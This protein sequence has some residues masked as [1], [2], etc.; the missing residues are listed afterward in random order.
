MTNLNSYKT[1]LCVAEEKNLTKASNKLFVSQPAISN[2]IKELEKQLSC[3]LFIRKNKGVE[4]TPYGEKLYEKCKS[5][6]NRLEEVENYFCE[7]NKE[8]SGLIKIGV[9]TSNLNQLFYDSITE[10]LKTYPNAEIS[11][12]RFSENEL[13]EGLDSGKLNYIVVDSEFSK[14]D[15]DIITEFNIEYKIIGNKEYFEKYKNKPLTLQDFVKENLI[16]ANKAY[17][18]RNNIDE[19]FRKHYISLSPKIELD[20]YGYIPN[21]VKA[22][23]GISVINPFYFNESIKKGELFIINKNFVFPKRK[24]VLAKLKNK[25]TNKFLEKY[26]EIIKNIVKNS[27]NTF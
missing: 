5:A 9:N 3:Q 7:I 11:I 2:A 4:L 23:Y 1:F 19:F 12:L 21:F 20:G 25:T 6:I 13:Y 16:L 27:K 8:Q 17:T 15:L 26:E 18:S 24:I 14:E 22:G 10:F